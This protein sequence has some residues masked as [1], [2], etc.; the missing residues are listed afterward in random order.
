MSV[1]VIIP[2][3]FD[4]APDGRPWVCRAVESVARQS[5]V[6]VIT[7]VLIAIDHGM[8]LDRSAGE[9]FD[10]INAAIGKTN[11][12]WT[13]VEGREGMKS[14]VSAMNAAIAKVNGEHVAF[15][16]DDDTWEP[17]RLS[18][19]LQVLLD[20]RT[21][22]VTCSQLEVLHDGQT[23]R[24]NDFPTCSGWLMEIGTLDKLT[25]DSW[26][27]F[28]DDRFR[29]HWDNEFL[30]RFNEKYGRDARVHLIEKGGPGN[31]EW[32]RTVSH[33][34]RMMETKLSN[35]LVRRVVHSDSIMGSAPGSPQRTARSQDEYAACRVLYGCV[36]W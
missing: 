11:A 19:G 32:A 27:K 16:E 31:R 6:G 5:A 8:S 14:H 7:E 28:F 26:G 1:S 30:G 23:V 34:S 33:Y 25:N 18:S 22:L 21:K 4:H 35:P 12:T 36:P 10:G 15:L 24:I 17:E 20:G 3:K 2:S 29:I 13:F 9:A